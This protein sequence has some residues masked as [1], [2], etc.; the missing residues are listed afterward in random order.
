M[1]AWCPELGDMTTEAES[2][3][4]RAGTAVL[5][6]QNSIILLD[7]HDIIRLCD[8]GTWLC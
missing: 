4:T 6:C 3:T 2:R 1:V 8:V 5:F 7:F